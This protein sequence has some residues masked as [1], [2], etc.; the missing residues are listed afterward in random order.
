MQE[1]E[2]TRNTDKRMLKK[3]KTPEEAFNKLIELNLDKR[4]VGPYS[5]DV[6]DHPSYENCNRM[7]K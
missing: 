1:D 5:Y 7:E 2:T 6:V 3:G 4:L